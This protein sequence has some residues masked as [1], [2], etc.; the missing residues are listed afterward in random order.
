M[1][2]ELTDEQRGLVDS[3]RA[4][5]AK[6]HSVDRARGLLDGTEGFDAQLWD[7]GADLGWPALGIAE[8]DG[9]LGQRPVDLA[10]VAVELGYGLAATPFIPVVVTADAVSRS[11][12]GDKDKLLQAI[13]EGSL[14]AA[15]AYAEFGRSWGAASMGTVAHRHDGGYL[16][17]GSKVSVQDADAA[18]LLLV[19][20]VLDGSP[21]DSSCPPTASGCAS[22]GNAPS[23]SPAVTAMSPSTTWRSTPRHCARPADRPHSHS[24]NR[25][26][27]TPCCC[28]P[29]SSASG[30]GSSR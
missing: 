21:P 1:N 5:L 19:D 16:L 7:R 24:P 17:R 22:T 9:G 27:C 8:N 3:T 2:F 15:W 4:L 18:H 14:I 11:D 25:C 28:A 23:T 10:L 13:S 6:L 20:A 30:S 26:V 12:V 29:S